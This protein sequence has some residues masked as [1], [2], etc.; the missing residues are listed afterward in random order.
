MN[1]PTVTIVD[2][3]RSSLPA[4]RAAFA[5]LGLRVALTRDATD[6]AGAHYLVLTGVGG[7][8]PAMTRLAAAGL[9]EPLRDRIRSLRPTLAIGLGFQLLAR[10]S[11][12]SPGLLGLCTWNAVIERIQGSVCVPQVGW[13]RIEAPKGAWTAHV[14]SI[15]R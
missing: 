6:V 10:H 14:V 11:E 12:E 3:G 5:R 1:A 4:T 7:F 15:G 13:N 8:G 2:A 9:L